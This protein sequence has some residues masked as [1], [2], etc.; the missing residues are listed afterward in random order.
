M[1]KKAQN[2]AEKEQRILTAALHLFATQGYEATAVP[3][4]A[5]KAAVGS[6]TIYRYFDNKEALVNAVFRSAK[7]KLKHYLHEDHFDDEPRQVFHRFWNNLIRFTEDNPE[8]FHFLELQDHAPYLDDASR[9]LELEVLAPISLFCIEYG[10]KGLFKSLPADAMM[11][12]IWGAFVGLMKAGKLGYA[13][14]NHSVLRQA[15][16]VCWQMLLK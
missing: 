5:L 12:M 10:R 1:S 14:L 15:E 7:A 6:G 16:E 3:Q 13:R 9:Q 4:V 2:A 8:D 11:A